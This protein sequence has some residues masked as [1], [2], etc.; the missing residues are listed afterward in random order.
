MTLAPWG[1]ISTGWR[2]VY[3]LFSTSLLVFVVLFSARLLDDWSKYDARRRKAWLVPLILGLFLATWIGGIA[4]FAGPRLA[5]ETVVAQG[6]LLVAYTNEGEIAWAKP[7]P[8]AII[9]HS[10]LSDLDGDGVKEVVVATKAEAGKA[11]RLMI[12]DEDG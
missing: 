1:E 12:L 7:L 10:R 8:S 2:V 4:S 3:Y 6:S 11:S 5:A 9:I